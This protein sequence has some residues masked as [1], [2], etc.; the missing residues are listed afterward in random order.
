MEETVLK[1]EQ[2]HF[3]RRTLARILATLWRGER[4]MPPT[5]SQQQLHHNPNARFQSGN[6]VYKVVILGQGGVGKSGR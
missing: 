1:I 4:I 3:I 2:R 6:R 5:Q